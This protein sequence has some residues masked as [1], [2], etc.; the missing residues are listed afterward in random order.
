MPSGA[1]L[2]THISLYR[3]YQY[4][5]PDNI[6]GL[7][8]PILIEYMGYCLLYHRQQKL[9]NAGNIKNSKQILRKPYY[10]ERFLYKTRY[11]YNT[12]RS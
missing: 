3:I 12:N 7:L 6:T 1:G 2:H 9:M 8:L 10:S 11:I 4:C 5:L